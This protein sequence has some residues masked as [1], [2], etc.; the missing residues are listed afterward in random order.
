MS[1]HPWEFFRAAGSDQVRLDRAE[2]LRN[3]GTLDQ[4]LWVALSC[5]VAGTNLDEETLK[6]I[7]REGSGRIRA[8]QLVAAIE[9]MDEVLKDLGELTKREDGLPLSSIREDTELGASILAAARGIVEM[10]G[11]GGDGEVVRVDDTSDANER[12]SVQP[13]NGDGVL[14]PTSV[15]DE[16]LRAVV[17]EI[18]DH[19]G[20]VPDRSGADGIGND[21]VA[22]FWEAL[23]N[24]EAW[25][26]AGE[27]QDEA[28]VPLGEQTAA[29]VQIYSDVQEKIDDFFTRIRLVTFDP[30]SQDHLAGSAEKWEPIAIR[31]L[32]PADEDIASF[33][34]ASIS[35]GAS[36]P[37]KEGIN[38]AWAAKVERLRQEVVVPLL[39]DIDE[40]TVEQ[41]QGLGAH[42]SGFQAWLS[43][44]AGA[45][46][47]AL[48]IER[49]RELLASD[50][51]AQLE[52]LIARDEARR[53]EAEALDDVTRAVRL[54]RDLHRLAENFVSFR[55]FYGPR[56]RNAIFQVGQLYLDGRTCDL[57]V[58]VDDVGAHSAM[59]VQSYTYLAY[60]E[61]V[62]QATGEKMTIAA[63]FTDGDAD[64]LMVGRNGIFYDSQGRDWDATVVK[65]IE[66]PLSIRQAFWSPYKRLVKFINEQLE[67]FAEEQEQGVTERMTNGVTEQQE[68]MKQK[69]E[70]AEIAP[71]GVGEKKGA[72]DIGKFAG[73][74]AAVGLAL[75]FIASAATAIAT[76]FLSLK[77]WQMPLAILALVLLISGPSMLVAA[78]KLR[79][80]SLAPILDASGWAINARAR[81]NIPFGASLTHVATLPPQARRNLSDPYG[82]KATP[83]K[84]YGALV[85]LFIVGAML[86][87]AGMIQD[88]LGLND[89]P[90]GEV[91]AA[92]EFETVEE[93]IEPTAEVEAAE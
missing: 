57:C 9:W 64:Y 66:Q 13:F 3:L 22:R 8:P 53:P 35:P 33:P 2:D 76:E 27:E 93:D 68:A 37:L 69:I 91:V 86:W 61:C 90:A 40:L 59:A 45:E 20:G 85:V 49:V 4:K 26:S 17:Q 62:R 74:F 46:V 87:D 34:I 80:R 24:F 50:A 29:A 41:W 25:W 54:Y 30:R 44:K 15:D 73:I 67:K 12:L 51:R 52:E 82:E 7:D 28:L 79:Q 92:D 43:A 60:C 81:L 16:A 18:L 65:L 84:L 83:W 19:I 32:S 21:E 88:W 11:K 55:D 5:P 56:D 38:P 14:P 39:G 78:L 89:E 71:E 47:E 31:V 1:S 72:F 42:F 63:A 36:L 77:L 58:R 75:G 10:G 70:G 48:G 23:A 6:L